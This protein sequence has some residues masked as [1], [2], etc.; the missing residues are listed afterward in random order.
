MHPIKKGEEEL[1]KELGM[2]NEQLDDHLYDIHVR[3]H[4]SHGR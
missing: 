3:E 4:D 2:D 1:A